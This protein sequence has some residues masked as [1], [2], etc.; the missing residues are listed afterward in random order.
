[1]RSEV[2]YMT[3]EPIRLYDLN[4]TL[5]YGASHTRAVFTTDV[6]MRCEGGWRLCP[7]LHVQ[8]H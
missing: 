2:F 7:K 4:E 5:L 8:N 6:L 3:P 1:M